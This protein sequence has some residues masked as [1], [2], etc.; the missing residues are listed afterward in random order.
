MR[1]R[2]GSLGSAVR[3]YSLPPVA[4]SSIMNTSSPR[5]VCRSAA[6]LVVLAA[7]LGTVLSGPSEAGEG[8]GRLLIFSIPHVVWEDITPETTPNLRAFAD[9]SAVANL[10]TRVTGRAATLGEG[11]AT[12]GAGTRAPAPLETAAVAMAPDEPYGIDTAAAEFERRT[13][14]PLYGASGLLTLPELQQANDDDLFGGEVGTI[15]TALTD[16]GHRTAVIANADEPAPLSGETRWIL[17]REA[18]TALMG[19]DGVVTAGRVDRGLVV[20]DPEMPL[21][22]RLDSEAVSEAAAAA[23]ADPKAVVL[24]E[25]SDLARAQAAGREASADQKDR[26]M[27]QALGEADALFGSLLEDVDPARDSVLVVSPASPVSPRLTVVAARDPDLLPGLLE[28]PQTRRP[29]FVTMSDIGPSILQLAGV[30]QPDGLEGRPFEVSVEG[31]S[32]QSRYDLLVDNDDAARFR[33]RLVGPFTQGYV[34]LQVVFVIAAAALIAQG[35]ARGGLSM[36][37]LWLVAILPFTYL[38]GLVTFHTVGE[39]P[40]LAFVALGAAVL[41]GAAWSL[42]RASL[43]PPALVL[44]LDLGV[45]TFSVVVLGSLLQLSTIFGDSPIVAGRFTGINNITFAQLSVAAILLAAFTVH[46][47][48]NQR[49]RNTALAILFGALIVDIMPM[50]GADVGGILALVPAFAVTGTMLLGVRIRWRSAIGWGLGTVAATILLGLLDL[51]RA[52]A[53]RSH[54]GRLFERIGSDGSDGLLLVVER[55]LFQNLR[56]ITDQP[57]TWLVV[58]SALAIGWMI[59]KHRHVFV[60]LVREIPELRAAGAGL[61]VAAI[62][63]FALNDSGIAIPGMMLAVLN[64]TIVYLLITTG[65]PPRPDPADS[66]PPPQ[67]RNLPTH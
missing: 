31:S 60:A 61:A 13:G 55:K 26:L 17:H 46:A 24:V 33:D 37:A 34:I 27:E 63:G 28:S 42:R 15:G 67:R 47:W 25:A 53:N 9:E 21:G 23:W 43:G 16:A 45:I 10:A 51:T 5:R 4:G 29:G 59:W 66:S 19:T 52:P 22:V 3:W 64:P 56:A 62:L 48:P 41:T 58:V 35:R 11:Y 44:G 18:A 65:A 57:W 2:V 7:L 8:S 30:E 50:W 36:F 20:D 1:G 49:G 12:I 54:L 40:F 14:G 38:A 39:G 6:G 32:A